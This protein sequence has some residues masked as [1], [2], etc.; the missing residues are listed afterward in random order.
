MSR[1]QDATIATVRIDGLTKYRHRPS[2]DD[3]PEPFRSDAWQWFHRMLRKRQALGKPMRGPWLRAILMGQAKRLAL[4]PPTSAWG[5]SMLAKRG[6]YAA[7]Q[8][9]RDAGRV[10][11][12]HP[13]HRAAAISANRRKYRAQQQ[14]DAVERH[15]SGLLPKSRRKLL[16]IG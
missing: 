7:Q 8:K 14:L 5:R 12:K 2:I 11:P 3:L 1:T 15:R 9:Y 6:G 4:N 10:G 13:T 16:P